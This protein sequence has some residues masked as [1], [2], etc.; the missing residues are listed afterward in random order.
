MSLVRRLSPFA[1]IDTLHRQM[2]RL[3]DEITNWEQIEPNLIKPAVE[4]LD[5]DDKVTLRVLI[6][7]IDKKDLDISVT[8]EEVRITG[9]YRHDQ[10]SKDKGYYV[11]EFSYGKFQRTIQLPVT[12]KNDQVT[13]DYTDG[14]LTLTLPK[15][16]EA[17]KKVFK[18]NLEAEKPALENT[19]P[20]SRKRRL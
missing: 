10:E 3:F 12:I 15:V 11:S 17:S 5:N 18:V 4:L 9:E 1:E 14:I 20:G 16:E 8:P 19:K 7:G 13:A 6:P 2:N